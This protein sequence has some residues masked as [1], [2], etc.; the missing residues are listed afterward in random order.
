M[1]LLFVM[2]YSFKRAVFNKTNTLINCK[3]QKVIRESVQTLTTMNPVISHSCCR[4]PR[5]PWGADGEVFTTCNN[6]T[7]NGITVYLVFSCISLLD[8]FLILSFFVI[9]IPINTN[10]VYS[11]IQSIPKANNQDYLKPHS[12]SSAQQWPWRFLLN[13]KKPWAGP[14]S[15]GEGYSAADGW[16]GKGGGRGAGK[17]GEDRKRPGTD[18]CIL[19]I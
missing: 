14:V 3:W 9:I 7:R 16:W 18:T 13:K 17:K 12:Q 8:C 2:L 5:L 19:K 1:T 10:N 4:C 15:Y 11:Y 6:L